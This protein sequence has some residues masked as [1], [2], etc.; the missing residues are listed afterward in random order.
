MKY[1]IANEN[2]GERLDKFLTVKLTD[3]TRSQVQK[4]IKAGGITV[5]KKIVTPHNF[6]KQDDVVEIREISN[7][8]SETKKNEEDFF[9][10]KNIF[11]RIEIIE[12]APEYLV[13]NK[14]A[15]LTVHGGEGVKTIT[16]VD[17]LVEKYPETKKVGEDPLRPGIVHRLDR[18]VSGLMVVAKTQDSFENLKKQ[19]QKRTA[20]KDYLALVYGAVKKEA[21]EI[22][23]PIK[24]STLGYKMAAMPTTDKKAEDIFN[25][26][27][28]GARRATTEF[29]VAKRFIN[30]TLLKLKIKTGR[31]HQIRVHLFAYG[32]PIVGDDLYSTKKTR[33]KNARLRKEQKLN[34]ERIFLVAEKLSFNDLAG[35]KKSFQIDLPEE[36]KT[37]LETVK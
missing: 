25:Y 29:K 19:F 8:S 33:E 28:K 7:K 26:N 15:G 27:I 17:W 32:A 20:R 30:Y 6:L 5:N 37:F 2:S 1:T 22:D 21:G 13:I 36:L 23:F 10:D 24:R 3:I 12:D 11:S 31:T 16:L 9:G 4:L 18:E 14:P 34:S 35:E